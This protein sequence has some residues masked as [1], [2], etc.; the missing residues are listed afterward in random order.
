MLWQAISAVR[1]LGRLNDIASVLIRYGF[2]DLVRRI[3]Q[4]GAQGEQVALQHHAQLVEVGAR[5]GRARQAQ[6]G[7]QLV[8]LAI[9]HHARVRLAHARAVEQARLAVI[10]GFCVDFHC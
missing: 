2:G 1:D 8:H 5:R 3:G 9:R 6:A 10:P 7:L 4:A